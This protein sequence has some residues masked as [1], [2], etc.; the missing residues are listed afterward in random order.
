MS[1]MPFAVKKFSNEPIAIIMIDL[2]LDRYPNNV[3]SLEARVIQAAAQSAGTFY[4][5]LD[6][7]GL[8]IS[9]SDIWLFIDS[10]KRQP[11]GLV[12]EPNICSIVVGTHPMIGVAM[13][14]IEQQLGIN[15]PWFKTIDE[16]LTFARSQSNN[17]QAFNQVSSSR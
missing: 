17:P 4:C 12:A 2:P 5:I 14:K 15:I 9:F 6:T 16:A 13:R 10:F 7:R 3:K 8:E 11:T 1:I